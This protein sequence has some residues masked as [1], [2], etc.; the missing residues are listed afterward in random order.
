M[1]TVTI[2]NLDEAGL[3][4]CLRDLSMRI[5]AR[6][7]DTPWPDNIETLAEL[8]AARQAGLTGGLTTSSQA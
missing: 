1:A 6:A 8:R 3:V 5:R 7:G 2:R 4:A